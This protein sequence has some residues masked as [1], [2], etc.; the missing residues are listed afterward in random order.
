MTPV[1]MMMIVVIQVPMMLTIE[2]FLSAKKRQ[3]RHLPYPVKKTAMLV[4]GMEGGVG[5]SAKHRACLSRLLW[6][7]RICPL[8]AVV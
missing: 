6:L 8:V 4:L 2:K 5:K 1:M 7:S 3:V